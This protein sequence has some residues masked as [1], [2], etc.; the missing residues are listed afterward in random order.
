VKGVNFVNLKDVGDPAEIGEAYSRA[1][2]DEIVL[3]DITATVEGRKTFMGVVKRTAPRLTVPLTV[4]G[5]ISEISDMEALLEAGAAAVSVNTAAVKNPK[6]VEEAV[7]RFGS[8]KIVV[9]IDTAQNS[10]L[11]SGFEVM[12]SGGR[13]RAGK[14]AVSWAKEVEALGAGQILPTSMDTDGTQGGY[15]IPMTRAI[16]TAVKIPVIAS[17]GAGTLEH[18]HD[19]ITEARADAVLVASVFHFGKHT[20]QEAKEYLRGKGIAVKS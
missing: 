1:G 6:L 10:A 16:A 3:L 15:D 20:I 18:L 9:A 19:A 17:G 4:G 7:K 13:V 12:L 11:P 8:D 14:D 2:A 5:G